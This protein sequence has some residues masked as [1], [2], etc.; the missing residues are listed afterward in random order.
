MTPQAY[1]D[2][3]HENLSRGPEKSSK[4]IFTKGNKKAQ[5]TIFIIVGI[6]LIASIALFFVFRGGIK[7][8]V[9]IPEAANVRN[10]VSNCIEEVG[11]EV[12]EQIGERGGCW[13]SDVGSRKSEEGCRISDSGLA[14]YYSNNTNYIPS[15][16]E[17]EEEINLYIGEKL[18]FCTKN[19][20]DF[21]ELDISQRNIKVNSK[22]NNEEII[23][24][25]DYF[26]SISKE[27]NTNVLKDFKTNI[28]I[29][30]GIIYDSIVGIVRGSS[31][32]ICLSGSENCILDV[33]LKND[34]YVDMNDMNDNQVMFIV[35][36]ENSKLNGKP[37]EWV[38]VIDYE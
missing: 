13:K 35:R 1:T 31:G 32:E 22:I 3:Q 33:S 16:K 8:E 5:L 24:D 15:K 4:K 28:P 23:L 11:T 36:D 30:L 9:T 27:N 25:V 10:L 38:F 29:R 2:S 26:V 20:V 37:F 21:P 19:F 34:L 18:F 12:I 14:I 7:Q 6:I 17:I